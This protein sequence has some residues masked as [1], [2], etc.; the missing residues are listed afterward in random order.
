M[1]TKKSGETESN[2]SSGNKVVLMRG[3]KSYFDAAIELIENAREIIHL[4]TYIFA[5]DDTGQAIVR[6]LIVAARRKVQVYLLVDGYGSQHL[7]SFFIRSLEEE[8]IHF[9]FFEPLFKSKYHYFGRRLHH[10]ILAVDSCYAL[11]GGINISNNYNDFPGKAA[12]LDFALRVEGPV[13]EEISVLCSKTWNG[14]AKVFA[15]KMEVRKQLCSDTA[16]KGQS[17]VRMRRNDWVRGKNQVSKSYQEI[18][19]G[20]K[21]EILIVCSYFLPG[22][23]FRS[24]ISEAVKRNVKVKLVLAGRSDVGVAKQAERHIY[25]WLLEQGVELFEYKPNVLHAKM[26]IADGQWM[27]L[28]SYNVNNISALAS[29]ELNLD[30]RDPAFVQTAKQSVESIIERDCVTITGNDHMA[31][32]HFLQKLWQDICYETVQ[33]LIFLFTFYFRQKE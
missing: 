26:A 32:T 25:R 6:A 21:S 18:F 14:F 22:N 13:V 16:A 33:L 4:Q 28:G 29:I 23:K 2:F 20:A 9:R 12:W 10:K 5:Q 3:G 17:F 24:L 30:V 7:E 19:T 27:T 8:G 31:H 15:K 1:S 11:V